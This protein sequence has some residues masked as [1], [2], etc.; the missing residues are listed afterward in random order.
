MTLLK[1]EPKIKLSMPDTFSAGNPRLLFDRYLRQLDQ[2]RN[3][4]RFLVM[5]DEFEIIERQIQERKL[6][7]TL[8]EFFRSLIQ[9]Y[10]WFVMAFAGL[11]TLQEM[12]AD[13]W[14]PL[15]GSVTGVP[16]GFLDNKAARRLITN[17]SA[18]FPLDYD[19]EALVRVFALTNGQPYLTQLVGHALV[20]RY[21][22]QTFEEGM[23]RQRRFSLSDVEAVIAAP[24]FFRDGDAYFTGVWS[25]AE[26]GQP[27]IQTR[28]LQA[29]AQLTDETERMTD[30]SQIAQRSGLD[31]NQVDAAIE[32]LV[33]HEIV[34]VHNG[35]CQLTVELLRRWILQHRDDS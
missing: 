3:Q 16:V 28:V 19:E 29:I 1:S 18:D 6:E 20:T 9:T 11:H 33:R 15:F 23:E 12:T 25:Q 5:V 21:N 7:P 35:R 32:A 31:Q 24:E 30:S 27:P 2:V 13:Y 26:Q 8:L 4:R 10:P 17:P 22:R 34:R 14:H